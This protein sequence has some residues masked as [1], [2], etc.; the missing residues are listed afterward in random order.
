MNKIINKKES[1]KIWRDIDRLHRWRMGF[2]GTISSVPSAFLFS[3]LT[4]WL[5]ES[6]CSLPHMGAMAWTGSPYAFKIFLGPLIHMTS[7]GALGRRYGHYLVWIVLAQWV[8]ASCIV[9]LSFFNPLVHWVESL[10]FCWMIALFGAI[11]DCALEGYRI[12]ATNKNQQNAVS[13]FNSLGYRIGMWLSSYSVM[14]IA[15]CYGWKSAF[16]TIAGALVFVG[17]LCMIQLPQPTQWKES[18]SFRNY[19]HLLYQGWQFFHKTYFLLG[20]MAMIA[21]HRLGDIF[22]RTL[23]S[24]YLIKVG[25]TKYQIANVDKGLGIIATIIGIR[26][27]VAWIAR[28]GIGRTFG[29]WAIV[30]ALMACLF[31][32]HAWYGSK[33][34]AL[35]FAS[36]FFNHLAGGLGNIAILTYMS[37]LCK[38]HDHKG[39]VHFA[40]LSSF[41][42]MG[43]TMISSATC[44]VASSVSWP[45]FFILSACMCLPALI[46]SCT[47]WPFKKRND[48]VL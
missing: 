39:T 30:Q 24:H 46:I 19:V 15:H 29:L 23:W 35:F 7:F 1:P 4:I 3:I 40:M 47:P 36:V 18:L 10:M 11:Q 27:G 21:S 17:G 26:F 8:I 20:I 42:A 9:L 5:T 25:Y 14:I 12:N 34:F 31:M 38:T 16:Y 2:F 37:N 48:T 41:G 44:F 32:V 43:R 22:L 6:G 13:G 45:T 33:S 28:K